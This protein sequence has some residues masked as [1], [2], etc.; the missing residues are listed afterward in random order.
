MYVAPEFRGYGVGRALMLG[1]IERAY[2][3]DGLE[4]LWL[5]VMRTQIAAQR[6]YASLG[7][8]T[9][10]IEPK[11]MRVNDQFLDEEFMTL[12]LR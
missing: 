11:A 10:G 7:F 5:G 2:Q 12:K 3:I 4:H 9:W 1:I 8:V 6:L